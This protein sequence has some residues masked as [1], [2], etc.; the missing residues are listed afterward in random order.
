MCVRVF[1]RGSVT[2]QKRRRSRV[3]ESCSSLPPT[4]LQS[5]SDV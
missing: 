5:P 3:K 2:C 4:S 1:A